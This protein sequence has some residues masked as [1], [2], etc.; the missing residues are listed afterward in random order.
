MS[1]SSS[2]K[3]VIWHPYTQ[4]KLF[5]EPVGIVK[6]KGSYVYDDKGRKFIDALSS[7]WTSIHGHSHPYI[8]KK[9]SAQL[10][11]LEHV[12]FAGF[13]HEPA[14]Q[15]AERLLKKLPKNQK[16]IFFSDNGS[17]A[18][19]VALKINRRPMPCSKNKRKK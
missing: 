3:K 10:K 7:W 16:R 12:I 17:T 18:V 15:L 8:A 5:P 1:L 9:V 4:H 13:T 14:V 2:D 11:K 6:A 19:E